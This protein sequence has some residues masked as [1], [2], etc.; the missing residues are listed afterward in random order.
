[1]QRKNRGNER[2][3]RK[4]EEEGRREVIKEGK[5]RRKGRKVQKNEQQERD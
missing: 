3:E 1:M 4:R 5:T 2:Q